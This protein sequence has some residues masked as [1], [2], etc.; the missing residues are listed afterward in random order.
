MSATVLDIQS[1]LNEHKTIIERFL[2]KLLPSQQSQHNLFAAIRYSVLNNGKRLRPGLV[3]ATGEVLGVS[4][5]T[6]HGAAAAVELIHCYSLI[7]D[8]LPAMD[9]DDL[10]RGKPTCHKAYN[11]A[12]AILAG[13]AL[14]TLAFQVLADTELNPVSPQQQVAMISALAKAIGPSGMILGQAEDMAAEHR[15][16]TLTELTKLHNH[17]TGALF[18]ACIELSL[19]AS[20]HEHT[21]R[22]RESLLDYGHNLGLAFQIQ[23]DILDVTSTDAELGKTVGADFEAGK[24]TF[25]SLLGLEGAQHHA[26]A[27][28]QTA[29]QALEPLGTA[30]NLLKDLANYLLNR[31]N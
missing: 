7:H 29:K 4:E 15:L 11:E 24:S 10:R 12:T 1:F 6:L 13:D 16:L 30:S 3:Y 14:Q 23:D 2:D 27:A 8:D 31:V 26:N 20:E 18:K 21:P 25:P 17:K 5:N 19:I 22:Y 9:D 28:L